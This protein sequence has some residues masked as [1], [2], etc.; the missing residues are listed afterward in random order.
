[1]PQAIKG[2][3]CDYLL[4]PS[5][6]RTFVVSGLALLS[7]CAMSAPRSRQTERESTTTE[8]Q[9]TEQPN[10]SNPDETL[11]FGESYVDTG[12][13]ITVETPTIDTTFRHDGETYDLPE[14]DALVFAPVTFYN[15]TSEG[16]LPIDGPIF[17]LLND[18]VEVTETHSVRH[19]KFDPSI[20]VR[21]MTDVPT[22]QRWTAQ[23]GSVEPGERLS[24][25]AV[26]RV[27][28][29][30]DLSSLRIVYESDRISDG[31][32]GGDVVAWTQ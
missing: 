9:E 7:G 11:Q 6:R 30:T 31:W 18:G 24:G 5:T 4:M 15:T 26:F 23:G 2:W 21:E 20:R 1:M 8:R 3:G 19:P 29:S 17:T 28:E 27:P 22:T 14:G 25:T 10:L 12:L 32:F 13:E 16:S